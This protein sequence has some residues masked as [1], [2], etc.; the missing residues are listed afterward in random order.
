MPDIKLNL[1]LREWTVLSLRPLGQ[2]AVAHCESE[3]RGA[4]FLSCS[5]IKLEA[6]EN[7]GALKD[8]LACDDI[9]VTSPA[10]ARFA[11]Q[12][13]VFKNSPDSR[14]FALGEGSASTLKKIGIPEVFTPVDGSNSEN[15]L[16]IAEL[17]NLQ[18]R[19]IGLITAPGGRGL[20][21]ATLLERG[22]ILHV[23]NMY[24]R[25]HIAIAENELAS[26]QE[27]QSPFAVLCSSQEIFS[28]FWQQIDPALQ[29][30]LAQGL[31]VVSSVRL[32]DSL[33]KAG[34]ADIT[35]SP[36]P[37]PDAMLAHLEHVQMLQVR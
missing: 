35:V 8:V 31:W 16:A 29:E 9:I 36:S 13:S 3:L 2:H 27:L 25:M 4:K 23:T 34:I 33:R 22:A 21:E 18:G 15:L 17:Q 7:D 26:L 37:R 32:Q 28:S 30:T 19:H 14:W 10:A 20:I 1:P 12:S 6:I 11:A 5:S 24:R